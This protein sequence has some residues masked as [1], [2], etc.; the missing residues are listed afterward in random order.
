MAEN[1]KG[2]QDDV[3]KHKRRNAILKLA[4][5]RALDKLKF[6]K[7]SQGKWKAS[8]VAEFFRTRKY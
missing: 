7:T 3:D 6:T 1:Q 4:F 2:H 8:G 5:D